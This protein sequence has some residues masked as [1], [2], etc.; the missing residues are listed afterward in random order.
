VSVAP[1]SEL[2]ARA[3]IEAWPPSSSVIS[4][5]WS[6]SAGKPPCSSQCQ[7]PL[8]WISRAWLPPAGK[9]PTTAAG[10]PWVWTQAPEAKLLAGLSKSSQKAP[11]WHTPQDELG[12]VGVALG[13]GLGAAL[14]VA[15]AL[16]LALKLG[17]GLGW[18]AAARLT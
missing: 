11:P 7:L 18:Q 1:P 9:T 17:L 15:V 12:G 2:E 14:D 8:G 13:A 10:L 3:R 16:G 6:P 4:T 5:S